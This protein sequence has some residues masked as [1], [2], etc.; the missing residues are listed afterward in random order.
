LVLPL[1]S[2]SLRAPGSVIHLSPLRTNLYECLPKGR[3]RLARQV[4]PS[5]SA[6]IGVTER[7][8]LLKEPA[9]FTEASFSLAR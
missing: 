4:R 5:A 3:G 6:T 9:R 1:P 8:Q 2:F 7:S